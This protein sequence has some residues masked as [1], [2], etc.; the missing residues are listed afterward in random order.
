MTLHLAACDDNPMDLAWLKRLAF[1]QMR[2]SITFDTF[3]E[4]TPALDAIERGGIALL[5]LDDHLG[6]GDAIT[7]L[8]RI[9]ALQTET[10]VV[11]VTGEIPPGRR[12]QILKAGALECIHKD[13]L[14][15]KMFSDLV[16]MTL[17]KSSVLRP[18]LTERRRLPVEIDLL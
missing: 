6:T 15:A 11:V 7:N 16:A 8:Q 13:A 5:L 1:Q 10:Q 18:S 14:D 17:A 4:I 2:T 9:F 12:E 3:G